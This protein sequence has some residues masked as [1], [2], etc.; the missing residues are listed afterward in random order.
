VVTTAIG[1]AIEIVDESCGILTGPNNAGELADA[2]GLLIDDAETRRRLGAA[3]PARASALSDPATIIRG[4]DAILAGL[5]Q[6][7]D[8]ETP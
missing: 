2:I 4:L 1:G 5:N 7:S 6:K 8:R 3:G